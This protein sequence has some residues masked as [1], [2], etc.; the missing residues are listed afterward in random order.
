MDYLK[1]ENCNKIKCKT[2]IFRTDGNQF[3]LSEM[4]LKEINSY[5]KN[6]ESSH[7]CHLTEKTCYGGLEV[8]AQALFEK[9]L[10]PNNKVETMLEIA[11]A[12]IKP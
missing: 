8:T 12:F 3:V 2:C 7:V 6:F 11:Q 5:L 4:R 9:G 10:I 1:P